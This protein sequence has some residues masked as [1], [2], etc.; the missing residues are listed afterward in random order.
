MFDASIDVE[1]DMGIDIE[2]AIGIDIEV[3]CASA[4][5]AAAA[6]AAARCALISNRSG[7]AF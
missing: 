1:L 4:P 6:M 2:V 7:R 5:V 3:L